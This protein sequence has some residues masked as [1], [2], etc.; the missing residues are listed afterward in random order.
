MGLESGR[1]LGI[2]VGQGAHAKG[3]AKIYG[4]VPSFWVRVRFRVF[5]EVVSY[6]WRLRWSWRDWWS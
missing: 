2:W 1:A 6:W 5:I 4:G 3:K